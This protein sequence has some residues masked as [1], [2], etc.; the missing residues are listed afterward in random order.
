MT[1]KTHG[2]M[3]TD[4]TVGIPQLAVTD[5]SAGQA[6]VTD[7]AGTMTFATIGAGGAV[8]SSTYVE[9]IF[10]GDDTT[11]TFTLSTD[12]PYEESIL[13]FIDGVAQPTSAFTLPSTTSIT[14]SPA[15]SNGAAIR[16][17]HL[18]IA[19]SVANNSITGSKLSMGGDV[20]GDVLYYNGTDYQRLGIGTAG[21]HLATNSATNAPEW[22]APNSGNTTTTTLDP[23]ATTSGS[24]VNI[25]TSLPANIIFFT[26][27]INLMSATDGIANNFL[28]QLG[29][30]GGFETSGY[31]GRCCRIDSGTDNSFSSTTGFIF[32]Q[33]A[34]S[35]VN[36][37][38]WTFAKGDHN[39]WSGSF[40]GSNRVS[41]NST[42][43]SGYKTL[44]A[45]LTQVRISAQASTF[46]AG[47]VNMQYM[48]A[49]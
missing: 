38:L 19:S 9:D 43:A 17:C 24:V 6:I 1:I 13:T 3:M 39:V 26:I 14:F 29:D 40:V 23:V 32:V 18:G 30:S 46:D 25:A 10:T 28:I 15:P 37:G 4:N 36:T 11:A 45:E 16:V 34:A 12:A 42:I 8:G 33:N 27:S 31:N 5:G 49:S 48:V 35:D 2:R 7:G 47:S 22:V 41:D 20:A 44:S 21:Q